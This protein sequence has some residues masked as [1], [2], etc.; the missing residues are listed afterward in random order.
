M[1]L[2]RV[3]FLSGTT[4]EFSRTT[5]FNCAVS[6]GVWLWRSRSKSKGAC[7][8]RIYNS[9][10]RLFNLCVP[11]VNLNRLKL[12]LFADSLKISSLFV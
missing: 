2:A 7:A 6:A 8:S 3:F 11:T 12:G 5:H 1:E 10:N 4:M 9:R